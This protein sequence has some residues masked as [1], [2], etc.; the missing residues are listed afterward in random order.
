MSGGAAAAGA[1]GGGSKPDPEKAA[2]SNKAEIALLIA[3][4]VPLNHAFAAI[5]LGDRKSHVEFS[6]GVEKDWADALAD[7]RLNS[8]PLTRA[9]RASGKGERL[10]KER[11]AYESRLERISVLFPDVSSETPLNPARVVSQ[12]IDVAWGLEALYHKRRADKL[13]AQLNALL[14]RSSGK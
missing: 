11:R 6:Q 14:A 7:L 13:Q 5:T 3:N 8:S 2:A 9:M 12:V 10:M 4:S 1:G